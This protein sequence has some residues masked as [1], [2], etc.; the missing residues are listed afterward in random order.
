MTM[1]SI[2]TEQV[3]QRHEDLLK[4][5][6]EHLNFITSEVMELKKKVQELENVRR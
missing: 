2:S 4:A 3:A 5:T 1:V 6:M